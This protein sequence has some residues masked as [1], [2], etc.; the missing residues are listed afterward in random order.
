MIVDAGGFDSD[1]PLA[2][3]EKYHEP[4]DMMSM[5]CIEAECEYL[6]LLCALMKRDNKGDELEFYE[7]RKESL[8]F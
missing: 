4:N 6:S 2:L 7:F 1:D 3:E 8:E 5:K